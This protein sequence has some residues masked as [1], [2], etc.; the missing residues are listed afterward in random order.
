MAYTIEYSVSVNT[1]SREQLFAKH[2]LYI[3][4]DNHN[5]NS[6]IDR[7]PI[8]KRRSI[9]QPVNKENKVLLEYEDTGAIE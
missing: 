7:L 8:P 9:E 6:I 1:E 4:G 3:E 2:E 5:N